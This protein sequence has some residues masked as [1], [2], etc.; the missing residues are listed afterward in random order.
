MFNQGDLMKR[1][2]PAAVACA[3]VALLGLS[4][5]FA[6]SGPDR[7]TT[8]NGVVEG[9]KT[10]DGVRVFK[11]I[12]FAAPPVGDLRWKAPQPVKNWT[13]VRAAD[14]FGASCMQRAVFGDMEFRANGMSEDCL[15]LNV[16]T[17]AEAASAKQPVLVYFYGGGLMAGDGSE[18]RYDGEAM[19]K[20]G[21]VSVT[22]NYRLAA[23]GF[24][25][26]PEL[27][28][29]APYKASGNYG[30]LDQHAA[31]K[32]VQA[33][34]AAFGG[35]P[36]RVT[37]AGES[38]GSRSVSVQLLSPLSKGLFAGAIMESGSVVAATNPPS[39][40]EAEKQGLQF[41]AL[42]K[43]ADLKAFRAMPAQQVLDATALQGAP[44]FGP[45]A[46]NYLIPAKDLVAL[47]KAGE[48]SRVP[49]LQGS[50]SEERNAREILGDNPPTPEGFAAALKKA[51]GADADR[52]AALYPAKTEDA[53]LDA[54]MTL[55]SDRGMA[56]NM[57][58]L[59]DAHRVSSGKPVYRY[60]FTRPRPKFLGAANQ[61]PGV[62]GGIV[63]GAA[64]AAPPRWRGA[65]H[66]AEIEYALGNLATN[67]HYAWEDGDRKVSQ[68]MLDFFAN[69][70][71]TGDPNGPGLP[72][73]PAYTEEGGFAQMTI[74]VNSRAEPENRA[75]L[76]LLDQILRKP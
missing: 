14:K 70:I 54:A 75:R 42:A 45:T 48:Q 38:A 60:L 31:L 59:G 27:S 3:I 68:V 61:T 69:F 9:A 56:Y 35:D 74:D 13:G 37:I 49:L 2:L 12:P 29:E 23:F 76:L 16:W 64:N 7:V 53:I 24:L 58:L 1:V 20:K 36:A 26:L 22:I 21:I 73:W 44:R 62:A 46:D 10:A 39:L 8:V 55:A 15:Y 43:A 32:W 6:A 34:I 52:V 72:K 63:T 28:A 50:N 4:S 30:F 66:S 47:F 65:V 25:A 17:T 41:M 51:F 67:R 18:P 33:N 5:A 57:W 11:G 40:A 71:R 19:A